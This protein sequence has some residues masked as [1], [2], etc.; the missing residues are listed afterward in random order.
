MIIIRA[1]NT[2]PIIK[3]NIILSPNIIFK[4]NKNILKDVNSNWNYFPLFVKNLC[5]SDSSCFFL[6][7]LCR[8]KRIL[9]TLENTCKI[10]ITRYIKINPVASRNESFINISFNTLKFLSAEKTIFNEGSM[11]KI[12]ANKPKEAIN[13]IADK[14]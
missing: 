3:K 11:V 1:N 6:L 4:Q 5:H 10:H 8:F 14:Q 7:N 9:K 2:I 12:F 13:S